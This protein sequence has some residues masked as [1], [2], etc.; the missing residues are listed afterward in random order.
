MHFITAAT[1]NVPMREYPKIDVGYA[2]ASRGAV[3]TTIVMKDTLEEAVGDLQEYNNIIRKNER[4]YEFTEYFIENQDFTCPNYILITEKDQYS[5]IQFECMVKMLKQMDFYRTLS[6]VIA[7]ERY[8][9]L[10]INR[11][12]PVTWHINYRDERQTLVCND[13]LEIEY[14]K[15]TRR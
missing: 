11:D 13:K 5:A 6:S 8:G 12:T 7:Y 2:K 9:F 15:L 14:T 4:G 10:T 1:V 3:K